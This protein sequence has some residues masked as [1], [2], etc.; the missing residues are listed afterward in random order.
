M[1]E[2]PDT[3]DLVEGMVE[4]MWSDKIGRAGIEFRALAGGFV[5][6]VNARFAQ[7]RAD[8]DIVKLETQLE[9]SARMVAQYRAEAECELGDVAEYRRLLR[10]VE[11]G[12]LRVRLRLFDFGGRLAAS[13]R[14]A[15]D[16]VRVVAC[17]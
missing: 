9:R 17:A 14:P 6:G 15:R 16:G 10:D 2:L 11:A 8:R 3:F 4:V 7:Y 13:A 5:S 1:S 12:G